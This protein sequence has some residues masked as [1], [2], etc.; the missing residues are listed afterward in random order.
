MLEAMKQVVNDYVTP[1]DKALE[2][3]LHKKV[4]L[5][6]NSSFKPLSPS[7]SKLFDPHL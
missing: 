7:P 6:L 1:P 4:L 2:R 3:D 5:P